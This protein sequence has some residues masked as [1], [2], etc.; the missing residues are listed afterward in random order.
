MIFGS[1]LIFL[2]LVDK[3]NKIGYN[4]KNFEWIPNLKPFDW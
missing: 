4:E 2:D 1:S 3:T